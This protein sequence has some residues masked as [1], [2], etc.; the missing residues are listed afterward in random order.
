MC[1]SPKSEHIEEKV[2]LNT[3][4]VIQLFRIKSHFTGTFMGKLHAL[5][6]LAS[7]R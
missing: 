4:E 7:Q 1:G 3:L 5:L 6:D 2:L